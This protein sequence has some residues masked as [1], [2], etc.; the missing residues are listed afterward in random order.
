MSAFRAVLSRELKILLGTPL[1]WTALAAFSLVTALLFWLELLSFEVAQ[2]RAM[3]VGDAALLSLLDFNDLLLGSVL[4]HAQ[5]LLLFIVPLLTMRLFADEAHKGTLD[6]LLASP[7]S[8]VAVVL[9]K[10]AGVVVVLL[11]AGALLLVYPALLQLFGR[12]V[13]QGDGVVDWPQALLGIAG[14]LACG[15]LSAALGAAVSAS[16]ASPS[17]AA[18]VT[19]LALVALWLAGSAAPSLDSAAGQVLHWLAPASHLERMTR[20]VLALADVAYFSSGTAGLLLVT[21][22]L[23]SSRRRS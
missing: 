14:L 3:A 20:G 12:A 22:R 16:T 7:A 2:Q 8:D 21:V 23:Y 4:L 11:A 10:L 5:V 17:S 15:T 1:A 19:A 18:L 13:V 9:G 6:Y